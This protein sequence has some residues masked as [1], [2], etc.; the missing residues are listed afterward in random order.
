MPPRPSHV[1]YGQAAPSSTAQPSGAH[2]VIAA[3]PGWAAPQVGRPN[4][5]LQN[6]PNPFK[7]STT[8]GFVLPA[9]CTARLRI[10]DP[11]GRLLK[12]LKKVCPKGYQEEI[13]ELNTASGL[14]Y[15][16]L[17]TPYGILVRKMVQQ[18]N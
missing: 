11:S 6:R 12:Q 5:L 7:G 15:Y 17:L 13:I 2:E 8:I 9:A 16:E 10:L 3:W 14:L 4:A 1:Q 18:T